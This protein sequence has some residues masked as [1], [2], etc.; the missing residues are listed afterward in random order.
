MSVC[1][2]LLFEWSNLMLMFCCFAI[3]W[4]STM[5]LF[6]LAFF[7]KSRRTHQDCHS[8]F[9]R[10]TFCPFR[11]LRTFFV[12]PS[13]VARFIGISGFW[14][15]WP[16]RIFSVWTKNNHHHGGLS[17]TAIDKS[18]R[19]IILQHLCRRRSSCGSIVCIIHKFVAML[20]CYNNY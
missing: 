17:T 13:V 7:F 4:S 18:G 11:G 9:L 10:L 15:W 6:F 8:F 14:I 19:K 16:S 5:M 2:I 20:Y 12:L 1:G 3:A